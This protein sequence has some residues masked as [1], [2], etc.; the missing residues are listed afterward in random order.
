MYDRAAWRRTAVGVVRAIGRRLRDDLRTARAADV[1][2]VQ[3]EA[4]LLGP[5]IVE[6]LVSQRA[7]LVLDLDDATYLSYTSPTYGSMARLLKWPGKTDWVIRHAAMVTCGSREVADHVSGLGTPARLIP[8]VVDTNRFRPRPRDDMGDPVTIGWIGSHSTYPYL[9]DLFDVLRDVAAAVPFRLLV[10]G[11]GRQV[12]EM[13]G[14][15]VEQRDWT[16]EG[17]VRDFQSLDIGLYPLRAD[18]WAQGK[19]GLKAIQYMSV[20]VPF[21]ATPVGTTADLGLPGPPTCSPEAA[22]SGTRLFA[23]FSR[24]N[25]FDAVWGQQVVSTLS[26]DTRFPMSVVSLE[27]ALREVCRA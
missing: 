8:T 26:S 14:V 5:P 27:E 18:G 3:R 12:P 21:V 4:M 15:T 13:P 25:S 9:A 23:C 20:G 11:G 19:A 22:T 16:L 10:I 24:T 2:L 6:W 17:E 7:P 1:V